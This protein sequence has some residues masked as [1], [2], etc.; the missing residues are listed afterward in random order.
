[1]I[2]I[3]VVFST[4][5]NFIMPTGVAILSLLE[6][7]DDCRPHIYVLQSVDVTDSDREVIKSIC[8]QYSAPVDFISMENTFKDSFEIRDITTATYYR[9]LIPWLMPEYD[10]V[11]YCDGD[12][13][14]NRSIS[15]IYDFPIGDSYVGGV[16]TGF[17]A[18][19]RV[20]AHIRKLGLDI[21]NYING[22]VLLINSRKHRELD[23]KNEFLVH[24]QKRYMFQDQDIMNIVCRGHIALMPRCF[25]TTPNSVDYFVFNKC[26]ESEVLGQLQNNES[27]VIIHYAGGKP[28][29]EMT[30]WWLAWW[31]TYSRSPFFDPM[32]EFEIECRTLTKEP[33]LRPAFSI[34][35]RRKFPFIGKLIDKMR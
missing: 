22:G 9:L 3:P 18:H 32:L 21:D 10:K 30:Y 12:I 20:G 26:K 25:N 19:T 14:F 28:W 35:V 34:F 1:M 29:K 13:V 7:S 24:A 27:P 8:N 16:Q 23:L 4:D 17:K 6:H 33:K 15:N 11:I 31:Q 2:I 5:H